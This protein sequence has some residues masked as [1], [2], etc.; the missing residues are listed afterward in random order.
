MG[1]R[2]RPIRII[3][4]A[5]SAMLGLNVAVLLA[6]QASAFAAAVVSALAAA[7]CAR[8]VFVEAYR[9]QREFALLADALESTELTLTVHESGIPD[10]LRAR[11]ERALSAVA[12]RLR[13][14]NGAVAR[15]E[16]IVEHA[17]S[18]LVEVSPDGRLTP[19]NSAAR[20]VF[21]LPVSNL[22]ALADV[23]PDLGRAMS[24]IR[25]GEPQLVRYHSSGA[26]E[27][28]HLT[29][30]AVTQGGTVRHLV[31][32][33]NIDGALDATEFDAWRDLMRVV[34]HEIINALTPI[35]SLAE[36]AES[37]ARD[38]EA[39][40][41]LREVTVALA[42]RART[43]RQF[44]FSYRELSRLPEPEYEPVELSAR[45]RELV[46]MA[47]GDVELVTDE[48][49]LHANVDPVQIEQAVLNLIKNGLEAGPPVRVRLGRV[50]NSIAI[51]VEDSGSGVP[52]SVRGRL[53]VPFFT[54]KREGTGVGLSL[55]R[56][57]ALGHRGRIDWQNLP[58]GGAR[59]ELRL[60]GA[61]KP[62]HT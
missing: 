17:P 46:M 9:P 3:L 42:A 7:L 1:Y 27:R 19:L 62:S 53:F 24:R 28:W 33:Q 44:I 45:I 16:G 29:A 40:N 55:V 5:F 58:T 20:T 47:E 12:K 23:Q 36:T 60:P 56:Q 50:D 38:L 6:W 35:S 21:E 48:A 32:M 43:L 11:L 2:Y 13:T 59:F 61:Y 30:R 31:A 15:L 49:P 54:T 18:P 41:G 8:A 39:D 37:R 51:A 34:N 10:R 14:L 57:I 4:W 26:V 25:P 52:D 22:A